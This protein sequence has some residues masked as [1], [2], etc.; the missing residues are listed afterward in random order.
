M[1]RFL[2]DI[3]AVG[4]SNLSAIVNSYGGWPIVMSH[5]D[6]NEKNLTWQDVSTIIHKKEFD[7]G[8]Y[9]IHV[10]I[11]SKMSNSNVIYVCILY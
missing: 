6:W 9:N 11:D 7:N 3:K 1:F 10:F 5:H 8:F 4:K 2:K